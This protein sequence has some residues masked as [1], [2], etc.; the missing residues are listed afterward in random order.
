MA[1]AAAAAAP[2]AGWDE[3][4]GWDGWRATSTPH[5]P[6]GVAAG[7]PPVPAPAAGRIP[8]ATGS[9]GGFAGLG[10]SDG[11]GGRRGRQRRAR[12]GAGAGRHRT[13]FGARRDDGGRAQQRL[14][15]LEAEAGQFQFPFQALNPVL[16]SGRLVQVLG[17]DAGS[18]GLERRSQPLQRGLHL[19]LQPDE[20]DHRCK[21]LSRPFQR[22]RIGERSA[23]KARLQRIMSLMLFRPESGTSR[24]FVAQAGQ[25]AV[26]ELLDHDLVVQPGSADLAL[27]VR[28]E[29][30]IRKGHG[31]RLLPGR[32]GA[33]GKCR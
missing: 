17:E 14:R 2:V 26:G 20:V 33:A 30:V 9:G 19:S 15:L 25:A 29:D 23:L 10:G 31:S 18:E 27:V 4:A 28:R 8:G 16:H 21:K 12:G 13:R 32:T 1:A 24:A 6:R 3:V 5:P 22:V 11:P 7:P